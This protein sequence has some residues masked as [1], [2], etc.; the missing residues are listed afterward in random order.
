MNTQPETNNWWHRHRAWMIPVGMIALFVGMIASFV[1]FFFGVMKSSDAY[2][3]AMVIVRQSP[4]INEALGLPINAGLIISGS[5]SIRGPSG[6][7]ELAIPV[8]GPKGSATVFLE[9]R[10]SAGEWTFQK[11]I[12]E[13]EQTG[14]R[15]DLL[16]KPPMP[17]ASLTMRHALSSTPFERKASTGY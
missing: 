9:A 2:K 12:V 5:I 4:T 13:I 10:K 1:I 11:L 15:I 17:A 3:Q 14:V 8:Y 16:E 6:D 7:A